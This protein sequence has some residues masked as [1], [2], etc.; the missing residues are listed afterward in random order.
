V[1]AVV[2][3]H[4]V[5]RPAR[6]A[7]VVAALPDSVVVLTPE[8]SPSDAGTGQLTLPQGAS[9]V[10]SALDE[11]G[12]GSAAICGVGLGAMVALHLA[13][14]QPER[15][16][17]LVLVTRQVRLSPV[18]MS[19]SA[20]VLRLLPATAVARLGAAEPQVI[21]LLDQVR[22]VDATPLARRVPAPALVLWGGRDPVN[23]R[24]SQALA[25]ALPF[26]HLQLVP[27]AGP[28][29]LEESPELLADALAGF[30]RRP[31]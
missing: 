31:E 15:V 6:W 20:A 23:R 24:A 5:E 11:A 10:T 26:G 13:A 22:P 3:L 8:L 1:T 27:G 21:A 28:R 2:L 4:G 16:D 9:A 30:L 17:S 19:V 29:W 18:L 12:L 14:E 7:A 25:S